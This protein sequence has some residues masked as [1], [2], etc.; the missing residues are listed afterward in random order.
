MKRIVLFGVNGKV[1]SI[2]ARLLKE[3][4]REVIPAGRSACDLADAARVDAFLSATQADCVLNCAAVSSIEAAWKDPLQ[5]HLINAV[6][7]GVMAGACRRL[8]MRFLHLSTDYVLDGRRPGLKNESAP[9]RPCCVY[10]ESKREGELQVQEAN[11][12]AVILRVSWV[13]GHPGRPSFAEQTARK[14]LAGEPVEAIADKTSL[15]TDVEDIVRVA[16]LMA[17]APDMAG[18]FHVCSTGEPLSWHEYACLVAEELHTRGL[19]AGDVVIRPRKLA[20]I[21]AF[22]DER[23]RH[24]AMDNSLLCSRLG[25]SLPG[26][27]A[28]VSRCLGRFLSETGVSRG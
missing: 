16:A 1:G 17:D 27:R 2:A 21:A 11:P 12:E 20:D 23:P 28:T 7:P 18:I 14:L 10:G 5:A 19:L 26:A 24:T 6:A 15:P 25:I 3:Q 22:L 9:C 13:C 4:G 8:G